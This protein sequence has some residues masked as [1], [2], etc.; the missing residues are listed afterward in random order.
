MKITVLT[1]LIGLYASIAPA[2]PVEHLGSRDIFELEWAS[3]PRISPDGTRVAYVRNS[4]D[5][6]RDQRHGE[7]WVVDFDGGNHRPLITGSESYR[8]PRWSPN[9]DRLLYVSSTGGPS[10]LHLRWMDTGQSARISHLE[11]SPSG[12]Q[13]SPDGR[14]IAFS[15]SVPY[16]TPAMATLPSK[17]EGAEWADPP[18]VIDR[19]IYRADGAGYT[20]AGYEQIFL[21][22]AEGGTARQL[23]HGEFNHGA[24]LS[25]AP[26]GK[27]LV[28][29]ANRREDWEFEVNDSEVYELDIADGSLR[30]LTDRRGPDFDPVV[31]PDGSRVAYLGFDDRYQGYQVTRLYVMER[32]GS[33]VRAITPN[34]DRSID[35]ATWSPE[36]DRLWV[37]YAE[38][39]D[40]KIARVDLTGK[41]RIVAENV[42]GLS[43]GRPYSGSAFDTS[44]ARLVYTATTAGHPADLVSVEFGTRRPTRRLTQ[45]N[46]DLFAGKELATVEEL[47][48]KSTFDDRPVQAWVAKPPGF[49][50]SRKYPLIL[51]I[52]GGPFANYGPRFAAEIQLF[53]AAGYVVLYVNPRGS[54]SYGAEFGNLIH[55]NYP[56]EDYDDLMSA[57][58]AVIDQG[59]V[60][61]ERLFVTGGSGGGVLTAWIVGKTDRFKA[62][63]SAKPV[64]NWTSFV[65]TADAYNFFYRYW[66]P[67]MPW[68][69]PEQ[70][71]QRSPLSLAGNVTTPTMLLTGEVDYRTPISESEQFYQALKLQR[72]DTAL[73][74]I[75]DASHGIARRP[76]QLIAKVEHI[77]AWFARYDAAARP[78]ET[79]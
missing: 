54:T 18:R 10:Q 63:V 45:L 32:D 12:I 46:A 29:S 7:I 35:R 34:L 31:S 50:P 3:D 55:H 52:H 4:M 75:P 79:E 71:W 73:V 27:H 76:S 77:L 11:K 14:S 22:P 66:F 6:M 30:A 21:L 16:E 62:A 8:S 19:L 20:E 69:H 59:S 36:G 41:V 51:E 61:P 40:T 57:V 13:W 2:Q 53:A 60:D 23:T 9:G 15:M 1:A 42:G 25:W 67:G 17:P 68:D 49:D 70:Y 5:I 43:L 64:I 37:S 74:R 78:S 58:D 72:V 48:T 56:G 24:P 39:G 44:G 65:F 28:F 33:D 38:H 26:D 47:W